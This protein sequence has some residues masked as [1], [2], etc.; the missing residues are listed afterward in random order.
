MADLAPGAVVRVVNRSAVVK[1]AAPGMVRGI[2]LKEG[3]TG[4]AG[5]S[6]VS[7]ERTSGDGSPGSLDTY[8]VTYNIGDPST[9]QVRNGSNGADGEVTAADLAA[10]IDTRIPKVDSPIAGRLAQVAADGTVTSSGLDA[11]TLGSQITDLYSS[12]ADTSAL[13]DKLDKSA[14]LSDLANKSTA[15]SNLE[16]AGS[17]GGGREKVAALSATTGTAT[18]DLN[19]ASV[20]T[21]TPTG[22]VTLA[23]SNAPATG[24]ACTVTVI[25]TQGG[26]AQTVNLP[27]G[28]VWMHS[29]PTQV[30]N[31]TCIITLLTVNGGTTWYAS[32]VVQP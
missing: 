27:S 15:R 31:K 1:V 4:P 10:A 20:F 5:R 6:I 29:A 28:G 11:A 18:G 26:T 19:T 16:A 22:T 24:T 2:W 32:A 30:A 17:T 3:P 9:F 23:F 12:K 13:A 21:V 14:N 8:T 25:V 7:I